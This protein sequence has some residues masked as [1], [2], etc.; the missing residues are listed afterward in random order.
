[1][2][3]TELLT[4]TERQWGKL[5]FDGLPTQKMKD[6]LEAIAKTYVSRG[7]GTPQMRLKMI[8]DRSSCLPMGG[9]LILWRYMGSMR[10]LR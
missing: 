3:S 10:P 4:T 5:Y 9:I 6:F 1:M 8:S 7:R 2:I